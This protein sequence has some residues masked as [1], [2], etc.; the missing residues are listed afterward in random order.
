MKRHETK[1][2]PSR[3]SPN[4]LSRRSQ[5]PHSVSYQD[6]I[7]SSQKT[8]VL[9]DANRENT[10]LRFERVSKVAQSSSDRHE[11]EHIGAQMQRV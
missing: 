4:A 6:P 5:A 3:N 1:A 7:D 10:Q 8:E 11:N 2:S 9:T